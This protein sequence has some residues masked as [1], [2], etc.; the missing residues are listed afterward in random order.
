M[1]EHDIRNLLANVKA[2]RMSRR[3]FVQTMVGAGLSVPMA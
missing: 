2:G 3:Q 1:K